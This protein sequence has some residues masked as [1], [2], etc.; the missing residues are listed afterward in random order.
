MDYEQ[1]LKSFRRK[2]SAKQIQ[3]SFRKH[4]ISKKKKANNALSAFLK[5][6]TDKQKEY[7]ENQFKRPDNVI[8]VKEKKINIPG[9]H[10]KKLKPGQSS[11]LSWI[12]GEIID[13]WSAYLSLLHKNCYYFDCNFKTKLMD[14]K[15]I[16]FDEL[17]R[18]LR[19]GRK[20]KY[21]QIFKYENIF[22]PLHIGANHWAL[23]VLK[24]KEKRILYLDSMGSHPETKAN[25]IAEV[26]SFFS[27]SSL[28]I[29]L[30]EKQIDYHVGEW[31][32]DETIK[33]P[34][35]HNSVDC[36]VFLCTNMFYISNGFIPNYTYRDIPVIRYRIA[37]TLL[38]NYHQTEVMEIE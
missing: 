14:E 10:L 22:I 6:L 5:E 17:K 16:E 7:I 27:Q 35:Q 15:S 21:I 8:F 32:V 3:K 2:I 1:K 33:S 38:Q 20:G 11:T 31:R 13:A 25:I 37:F 26:W 18:F 4:Q 29:D 12:S 19:K 24:I 28:D 34:Q 9:P 30:N 23:I 36:G